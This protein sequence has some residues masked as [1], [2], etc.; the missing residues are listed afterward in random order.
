MSL[1]N[2]H[3]NGAL[4]R[5]DKHFNTYMGGTT[6]YV[7]KASLSAF[8]LL[9]WLLTFIAVLIVGFFLITQFIGG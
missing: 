7:S 1:R 4:K 6:G 8:T 9:R 3:T 5:G 2:K